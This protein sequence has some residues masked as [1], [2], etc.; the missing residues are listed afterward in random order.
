MNNI[1]TTSFIFLGT[2]IISGNS[3]HAIW[4]GTAWKLTGNA[5]D[6]GANSGNTRKTADEIVKNSAVSQNDDHLSFAVTA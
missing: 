5:D 4:N 1:G 6:R 3:R 2:Q